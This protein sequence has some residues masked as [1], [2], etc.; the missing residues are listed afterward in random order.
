M[1]IDINIL[2]RLMRKQFQKHIWNHSP[3][4]NWLHP[5]NPGM[6][7]HKQINKRNTAH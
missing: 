1:N 5:S 4:P 2:N 6:V 3:W 7:Q